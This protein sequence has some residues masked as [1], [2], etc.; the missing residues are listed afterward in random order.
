[1]STLNAKEI[2]PWNWTVE[3]QQEWERQ[4]EESRARVA[5]S[6]KFQY[7]EKRSAILLDILLSTPQPKPVV[8][9]AET[10]AFRTSYF[11]SEVRANCGPLA[12]TDAI[13]SVIEDEKW[14]K[15]TRSRQW[16]ELQTY[17][18]HIGQR[19]REPRLDVRVDR[20]WRQCIETL[21]ELRTAFRIGS[22]LAIYEQ[23]QRTDIIE[24]S[25]GKA[26]WLLAKAP[27]IDGTSRP[28]FCSPD[29]LA[30]AW[31]HYYPFA[32]YWAAY[33]AMTGELFFFDPATL[34]RFVCKASLGRFRRLAAT[35][36]EFRRD[37][38]LPRSK[39]KAYISQGLDD[40]NNVRDLANARPIARELL[41]NLLNAQQWGG[42]GDYSAPPRKKRD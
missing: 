36:L 16:L 1:M 42:L 14:R 21:N 8:S 5:A 24:P 33:A 27:H 32:H 17:S 37:V 30:H 7:G 11:S 6:P 15:D 40:Y 19:T 35:Y 31:K 34:V 9:S 13:D 38:A 12:S 18:Y 26:H 39:K 28:G 2:N 10:K 20:N 41:P 3:E 29:D 4:Q 25:L 22:A 23:M